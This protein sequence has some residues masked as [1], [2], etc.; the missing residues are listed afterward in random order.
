MSPNSGFL[1]YVLI[2]TQT[3]AVASRAAY[4]LATQL[5]NLATYLP[6]LATHLPKLFGS[7]LT[8]LNDRLDWQVFHLTRTEGYR[9]LVA[10]WSAAQDLQDQ[11]NWFHALSCSQYKWQLQVYPS[12]VRSTCD[13]VIA[14]SSMSDRPSPSFFI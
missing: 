3:A 13:D 2:R 8:K 10:G 11:A 5:S 12:I 7:V 1:R 14:R 9:G 4:N 6:N